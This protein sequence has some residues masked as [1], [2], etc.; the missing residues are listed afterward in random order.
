MKIE[1]KYFSDDGKME[2]NSP[3][4]DIKLREVGES[5]VASAEMESSIFDLGVA[6]NFVNLIWEPLAQPA[7]T[8]DDS[9]RFQ[10][11]TSD[12][13]TTPTWDY[14]GPDGTVGTFYD[15]Q[16]V[17]INS[18]HNGDQYLRYKLFLSTASTTFT[19]V[20]SDWLINYIT[21]CTP[22]GQAYFGGLQNQAYTLE[23]THSG[24]Q[25]FNQ[26]ITPSGDIIAGVE[27][28]GS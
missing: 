28:V 20:V 16:N 21:S 17:N 24:Y 9:A 26:E 22:P 19:P 3:S 6:S 2:I 25:T 10:L 5:Y 18:I 12:T 15:A 7:E 13:T 4:G 14:F 27:L 1:T 11:A 8:G 23:V